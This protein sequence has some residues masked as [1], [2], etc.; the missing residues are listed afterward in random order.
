MPTP[1][2]G[3][4]EDQE[5]D[6][7]DAVVRIPKGERLADSRRTEG[8]S[9]GFTPKSTDKG[10]GHV[11]IRLK[12]TA[13]ADL[14]QEP[15]VDYVTEYVES[16]RR[17]LTPSEQAMADFLS[18]VIED[19]YEALKPVVAHWFRVRVVPA[20]KAKRDDLRQR[21]RERKA[22]KALQVDA[23]ES[24]EQDA[25][26]PQEAAV[27][28]SQ[29]TITVTSEQ[30]QELFMMWLVREDAQQ[31]LWQAIASAHIEDGDAT[32]LAWQ[33]DLAEL[34]PQERSER[35]AEILSSNPAILEGLG[36]ILVAS[37]P[38]DAAESAGQRAE[39]PT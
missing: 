13:D 22:T 7:V 31:L 19:L 20:V 8:W 39:G 21:R 1:T 24:T 5:Y 33:Q 18:R 2:G 16:P 38:L 14:D 12:N 35:V 28:P 32:T 29:P 11:E 36:R 10:P 4:V 26:T 30:F 3:D 23:S 25:A 37:L 9:R 34:S 17:E 6:E 15:G 27:V